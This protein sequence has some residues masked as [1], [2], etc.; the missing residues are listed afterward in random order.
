MTDKPKKPSPEI[1]AAIDR[2]YAEAFRAVI[3]KAKEKQ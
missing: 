2:G 1:Q 3:Q